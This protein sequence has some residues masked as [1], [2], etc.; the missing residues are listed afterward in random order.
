MRRLGKYIKKHGRHFTIELAMNATRGRWNKEDIMDKVESQVYYNVTG[1]TV[2]DIVFLVNFAKDSGRPFLKT[3]YQCIKFAL[4]I[5]GEYAFHSGVMFNKW[6]G[7][8]KDF[9]LTPYI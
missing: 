8:T 5:V 2:G 6:V 3:K 7:D 9:D 4:C 1:S